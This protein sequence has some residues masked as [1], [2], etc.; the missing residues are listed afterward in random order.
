MQKKNP[1]KDTAQARKEFWARVREVVDDAQFSKMLQ[2]KV[3]HPV[4]ENILEL[5]IMF[6][7]ALYCEFLYIKNSS[8]EK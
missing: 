4:K 1:D 7:E 8:G 6:A 2:E 5:Q 3:G